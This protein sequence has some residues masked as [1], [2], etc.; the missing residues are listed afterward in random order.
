MPEFRNIIIN[1]DLTDWYD[2]VYGEPGIIVATKCRICQERLTLTGT[3]RHLF[4][5]SDGEFEKAIGDMT[6]NY[7][8]GRKSND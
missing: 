4:T 7:V 5:H 1:I 8:Y 6:M 3:I 2:N